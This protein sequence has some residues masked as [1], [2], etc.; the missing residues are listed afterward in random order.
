MKAHFNK[1]SFMDLE[2][3][4]IQMEVDTRE[5][6]RKIKGVA[7]GNKYL[8]MKLS[9][10]ELSKTTS[11][12]EKELFCIETVIHLKVVLLIIYLM[13]KEL[14][15]LQLGSFIKVIL[16]GEF[17]KVMEKLNILMAST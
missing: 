15:Q 1:T 14:R 12:R 5:I 8:K 4:L 17:F 16:I 6:G 11:W 7:K 13:D 3:S 2:Y 10:L 9:I